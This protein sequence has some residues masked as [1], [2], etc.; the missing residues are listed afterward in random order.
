MMNVLLKNA[1]AVITI[2]L[3]SLVLLGAVACSNRSS[4]Q[5][6]HAPG[7]LSFFEFGRQH[8]LR[9]FFWNRGSGTEI[10]EV[11]VEI[12]AVEQNWIKVR[13]VQQQ[14]GRQVR[15]LESAAQEWDH[16]WLNLNHVIG[17]VR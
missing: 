4:G 14:H 15:E 9:G 8:T 13:N 1:Y 17:V 2:V 11:T 5:T 6:A 3:I 12:L 7:D 16:F 10:T